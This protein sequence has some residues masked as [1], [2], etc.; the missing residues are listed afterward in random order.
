M[1][2]TQPHTRPI[3]AP[4][5]PET[6][7]PNPSEG[8]MCF[9]SSDNLAAAQVTGFTEKSPFLQWCSLV[10]KEMASHNRDLTDLRKE[11]TIL[12]FPT[13]KAPGK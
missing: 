7:V 12:K 13:S 10:S 2:K 11:R 8:I 1:G 6:Q 3:P 9:Q 5:G 4:H